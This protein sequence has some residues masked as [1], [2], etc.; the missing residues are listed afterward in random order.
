MNS[1]PT[2]SAPGPSPS[3]P[4]GG[5]TSARTPHAGVSN[6]RFALAMAVA[7]LADTVGLP[8]GEFGVVVFDVVIGLLL[9]LCLRGFRPE[10]IIACLV[11]AIP[12]IGLFP[13][14]SL[15]VP[16]IWAR[17]KLGQQ[18]AT[19]AASESSRPN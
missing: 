18:K 16:A 6:I 14:W 15:A 5:T 7:V 4:Q 17:M 8:F 9:A 19:V 10:I 1:L 2:N 13:S 12:G 11:E 3:T